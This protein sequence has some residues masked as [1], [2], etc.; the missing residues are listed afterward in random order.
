MAERARIILDDSLEA[1][2]VQHS[3]LPYTSLVVIDVNKLVDVRIAFSYK[4]HKKSDEEI[5]SLIK[6][7]ILRTEKPTEIGKM[8]VFP[9]FLY[10][11]RGDRI[12]LHNGL[13][14][15]YSFAADAHWA[16]DSAACSV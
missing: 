6:L 12:D 14:Y 9:T 5:S 10:L 16:I 2:P 11:K 8:V 15:G 13:F 1:G 4:K 3:T 7:P